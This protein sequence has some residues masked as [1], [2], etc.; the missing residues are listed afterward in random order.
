M[1]NVCTHGRM[2]GIEKDRWGLTLQGKVLV[3]LQ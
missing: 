2:K 1:K 3:S